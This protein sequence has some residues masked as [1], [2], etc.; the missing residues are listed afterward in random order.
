M[1]AES[2]QRIPGSNHLI[3]GGS[4]AEGDWSQRLHDQVEALGL[5]CHVRFMGTLPPADL[6]WPLSAAEVFVLATSNEGWANVFLEAMACGLPV[7]AT[8]VGGN[9]EVV[10]NETLGTIVPFGD[11]A[12]LGNALQAALRKSWDSE[13]IMAYA[14][15]N[16][17]NSRVAVLTA[18]FGELVAK[19]V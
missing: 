11:A 16:S 9:R 13:Q 2:T 1:S 10:A 17:W 3:I 7:V 8:D 18:Q 4:S 19:A 14:R 15:G 5:Q 6:K 12:A